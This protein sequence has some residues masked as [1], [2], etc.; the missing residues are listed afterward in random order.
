M[1]NKSQSGL[2]KKNEKI[3]KSTILVMLL[4]IGVLAVMLFTSRR[5]FKEVTI[6]KE[7]AQL[8]NTELQTELDSLVAEYNFIKMEYDSVLTD[9]DSIIQ[10][11]AAEIQK[12]ISQQ[13][14]YYRIRRQLNLLREVT[15]NYVREIDSLVTVTQVLKDENV[16]MRQEIQRVNTRATE[17]QQD[18]EQLASQVEVASALRAYQMSA[19]GI[20]MRTRGREDETDR[21][22]RVEQ[23]KVCFSV[24]ENLVARAG[25]TNIYLRIAQPN[26]NILRI[27]DDDSYSFS[28]N[29]EVL[30][31]SVKGTI[32]YQNREVDVCLYWQ[33][34]AELEP[35]LYL[36]SIYTDDYRL[37]ETALTLR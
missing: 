18:K 24:A 33:R 12:L 14:D 8:L 20:R 32:D 29:G 3:Y 16:A 15:Q 22:S 37:G 23:I 21:A 7:S 11:N 10:A 31:Y 9:K 26:G 30:Q 25:N 4:I 28:H 1:E 2:D 34:I 35:G 27:S 6:D 5:S 13:A 17:L 36:I 19:Q